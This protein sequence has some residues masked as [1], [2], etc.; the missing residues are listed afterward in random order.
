MDTKG[1]ESSV[2]K[3]KISAKCNKHLRGGGASDLGKS[4]SAGKEE[5]G[6][7]LGE[8]FSN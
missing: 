2:T 3:G 1:G 6:P 4:I 8:K 5:R 7:A